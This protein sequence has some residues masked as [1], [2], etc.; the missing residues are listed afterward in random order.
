M[1]IGLAAILVFTIPSAINAQM[2]KAE[3]KAIMDR[4]VELHDISQHF[5]QAEKE[6][7]QAAISALALPNASFLDESWNSTSLSSSSIAKLAK[8]CSPVYG[9]DPEII[10]GRV[11]LPHDKQSIFWQCPQSVTASTVKTIIEYSGDKIAFVRDI[12]GP[13]TPIVVAPR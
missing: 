3:Q 12:A 9:T 11:A 1:R 8:N 6:E 2:T 7:N 5:V 13:S 10:S 4:A